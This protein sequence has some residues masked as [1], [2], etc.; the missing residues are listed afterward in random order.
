MPG[1]LIRGDAMMVCLAQ[2]A[3]GAGLVEDVNLFLSPVIVGG[4]R[5]GLP[6]SLRV[7]LDLLDGRR[8]GSGVVHL[9]YARR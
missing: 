9:H 2:H 4:G 5:P 6:R 3:F 7:D 1:W 8:F